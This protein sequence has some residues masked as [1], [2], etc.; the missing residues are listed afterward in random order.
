MRWQC[1]AN[2]ERH[3]VLSHVKRA[4]GIRG[5]PWRLLGTSRLSSGRLQGFFRLSVRKQGMFERCGG[6]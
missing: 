4:N 1:I 6:G 5:Y 3:D 2:L